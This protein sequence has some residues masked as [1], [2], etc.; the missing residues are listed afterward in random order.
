METDAARSGIASVRAPGSNRSKGLV[1]LSN[2][3]CFG[4]WGRAAKRW[5]GG[6]WWAQCLAR[7]GQPTTNPA[8]A[9]KGKFNNSMENTLP[10]GC[11]IALRSALSR[12]TDRS[13]KSIMSWRSLLHCTGALTLCLPEGDGCVCA[14]K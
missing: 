6:R 11:E 5:L 8:L 2:D 3:V 7:Q 4:L 12:A 10:R 13:Q 1:T 14:S 9:V